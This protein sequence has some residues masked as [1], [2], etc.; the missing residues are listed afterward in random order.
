MRWCLMHVHA[1]HDVLPPCV[2]SCYVQES[3]L[4][5]IEEVLQ[6]PG[7]SSLYKQLRTD[8]DFAPMRA[9]VEELVGRYDSPVAAVSD[10]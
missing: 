4:T 9:S 3:C 5:C 7:G 10:L 2:Q 6:S 1:E 8:P